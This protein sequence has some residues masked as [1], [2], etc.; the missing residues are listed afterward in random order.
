[1]IAAAAP[2]FVVLQEAVDPAGVARVAAASG[3]AHFGSRRGVSV[4]FLSRTP[5]AGYTW[6]R[7]WRSQHAFLDILPAPG[8]CRIIGVH[9]SAVH[10][11]VTEHRRLVELNALIRSVGRYQPACHV[12]TGDFNTLAPGERLDPR[13]LPARLRPLVW[14]SGGRIRWRTIQ[15]ILDHDYVDGFRLRHPDEPGATFPVW[16]PHL[17]LDYAFMPTAHADRLIRCEVLTAPP[18]RDASDHFPLLIEIE[19]AQRDSTV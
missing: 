5:V 9:L 15:R 6:H 4:A 11:S 10:S 18:A 8:A 17:R 7:P 3:F 14:L 16:H 12:L 2:D 1:V 13:L 19:D